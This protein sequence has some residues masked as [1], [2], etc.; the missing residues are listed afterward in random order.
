MERDAQTGEQLECV[1]ID[2]DGVAEMDRHRRVIFI[3]RADVVRLE[4]VMDPAR[5]I[6]S[7]CW[8]S[9]SFAPLS[10]LA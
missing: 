5:S 7:S 4:I 3:P 9:G 6:R 2:A 8:P 10:L 1:R